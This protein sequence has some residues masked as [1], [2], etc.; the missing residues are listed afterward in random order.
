MA[1]SNAGK[2]K[3]G[4][5]MR[6]YPDAARLLTCLRWDLR[7]NTA[8]A[9]LSDTDW[10]SLM[11]VLRAGNGF[12]FLSRRLQWA[13][14]QPPSWV[15][16]E[17]RMQAKVTVLRMLQTMAQLQGCFTEIDFPVLALKG[18]DLAH[19]V[20]PHPGVRPMGDC[21]LLVPSEYVLGMDAVLRRHGYRRAK[22][23]DA[24]MIQDTAEHHVLYRPANGDGLPVEVHWRLSSISRAG[25]E[26]ETRAILARSNLLGHPSLSPAV[27][28][29]ELEDLFLYLCEHIAHHGFDT[30]LTQV[31]DLAE[32]VHW[33]GGRFDWPR[34]WCRAEAARLVNAA[35]LCL[36]Q[37]ENTLG[38]EVPAAMTQTGEPRLPERTLKCLPEV[39]PNLGRFFHDR[40]SRNM[41][42]VAVVL[43]SNRTVLDWLAWARIKSLTFTYS[44]DAVN[45]A[46][47]GRKG[48]FTRL[49][50]GLRFLLARRE[51][52]WLC[53]T[54]LG[55]VREKARRRAEI[56][57]WVEKK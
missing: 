35:R 57:D 16:D 3:V 7:G 47:E 30:S 24:T 2:I 22:H 37:L 45:V 44:G 43:N 40:N 39:L 49:S 27:R 41:F 20:Y 17:L 10:C 26:Q 48:L 21:D 6:R 23:L 13:P 32:V 55:K 8:L 46:T 25:R 15:V 38:V 31:W 54:D 14:S 12:H 36:Y 11:E 34:F 42:G 29:M 5:L 9:E 53:L 33:G 52:I 4:R 50:V 28:V 51:L 19:R 18:L 1:M 56:V